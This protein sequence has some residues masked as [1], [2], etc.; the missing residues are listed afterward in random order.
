MIMTL[1]DSFSH[2][3]LLQPS[4]CISSTI[5]D[6]SRL[7][8]YRLILGTSTTRCRRNLF[9]AKPIGFFRNALHHN[10]PLPRLFHNLNLV[11]PSHHVLDFYLHLR[12]AEEPFPFDAGEGGC[13]DY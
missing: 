12:R 2:P 4:L 1:M 6:I 9:N 5:E 13:I 7:E 11:K 8:E 10:H 3:R